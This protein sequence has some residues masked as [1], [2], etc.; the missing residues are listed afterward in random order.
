[1]EEIDFEYEN[2]G[3]KSFSYS[4]IFKE[5]VTLNSGDRFF[6]IHVNQIPTFVAVERLKNSS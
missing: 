1:M 3:D 5:P 2:D 4:I 6:I